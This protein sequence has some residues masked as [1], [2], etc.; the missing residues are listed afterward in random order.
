[1]HVNNLV[2]KNINYSALVFIL[3]FQVERTSAP[4]HVRNSSG[5]KPPSE[6]K[7]PF[8]DYHDF[9]DA[10]HVSRRRI[11]SGPPVAGELEALEAA[12]SRSGLRGGIPGMLGGA[13]AHKIN[14]APEDDLQERG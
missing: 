13:P 2:I 14:R 8:R 6:G 5:T 12:H 10:E 1:M 7:R 11:V 4:A 3:I 9:A